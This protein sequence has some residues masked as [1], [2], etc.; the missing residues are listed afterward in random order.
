MTGFQEIR[1]LKLVVPNRLI[2][3]PLYLTFCYSSKQVQ[4]LDSITRSPIFAHAGETLSGVTMVR[5]FRQQKRFV[6]ENAHKLDENQKAYYLS[7]S[8][9]RYAEQLTTNGK[10]NL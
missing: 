2:S 6:Q 5:A 8:A 10:V 4:R 1:A 9:N 7:I 3:S